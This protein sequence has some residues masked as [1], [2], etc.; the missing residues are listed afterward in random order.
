MNK[1]K[2]TK[3][4]ESN[5]ITGKKAG[6][7]RENAVVLVF[8][9]ILRIMMCNVKYGVFPFYSVLFGEYLPIVSPDVSP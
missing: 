4:T 6:H 7:H 2:S 1:A 9:G 3:Y 5:G 8:T